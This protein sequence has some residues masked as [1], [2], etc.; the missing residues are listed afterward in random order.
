MLLYLILLILSLIIFLPMIYSALSAAPPVSTKHKDVDRLIK[1]AKIQKN[2]IVADLG[3][4]YGTLIFHAA[5]I[6]ASRHIIGY[7]ISPLHFLLCFCLSW[8]NGS[9]KRVQMRFQNFFQSNLSHLNVVLIFITPDGLKKL[10]PK[11]KKDLIPGTRVVSYIFPIEGW[12]PKAVSKPS[13]EDFPIYL[14]EM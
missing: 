3:A 11:L 9:H 8:L 7:E 1:L 4:G 14:Y 13:P 10:S 6:T 12:V 2:D 5:K